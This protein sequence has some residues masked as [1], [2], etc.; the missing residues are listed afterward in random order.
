YTVIAEAVEA[1]LEHDSDIHLVIGDPSGEEPTMI[2]EF[3]DADNC[4]TGADPGLRAKMKAARD[5]FVSAFG[6]PPAPQPHKAPPFVSLCGTVQVTGVAFFDRLH[7][8]NG[9]AENGI[10]LHPVLDFQVLQ[11]C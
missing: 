7:N 2:V 1:G 4:A 10:E 8:Q 9:V 6:L 11:R 3:P 5:A